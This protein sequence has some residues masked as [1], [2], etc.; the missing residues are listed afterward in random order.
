[1]MGYYGNGIGWMWLW[2]VLLLV[3]IAALVLLTVRLIAAGEDPDSP[4]GTGPRS[5]AR[6]GIPRP[7]PGIRAEK[8][9]PG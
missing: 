2:G 7:G 5:T 1:M 4:D 6:R 8:A 9:R 3:G